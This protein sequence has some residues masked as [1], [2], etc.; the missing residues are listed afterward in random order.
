MSLRKKRQLVP[1]LDWCYKPCR[2][3]GNLSF[4]GLILTLMCRRFPVILRLPA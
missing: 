1:V 4:I 3:A 2:S